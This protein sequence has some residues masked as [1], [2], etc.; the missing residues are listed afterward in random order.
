MVVKMYGFSFLQILNYMIG[1]SLKDGIS[2]YEA[3]G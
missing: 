2:I 3:N 1:S